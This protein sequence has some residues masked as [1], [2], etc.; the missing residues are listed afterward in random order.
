MGVK[1]LG[2]VVMALA[3]LALSATQVIAIELGEL[4]AVPGTYPPYVFRLSIIFSLHGPSDIPSV[5]VRQPRDVLSLVKNNLLEL[6]LPS[7]TDVELEVNQGGQTLNRL[8]LKGELQAA[9]A[10]LEVATMAVRHQ[11]ATVK[12]RQGPAA[13]ARPLTLAAAAPPDQ[14]L[15]E[16]ELQE[17]RQAIQ[18]LMGRVT[19]W[20]GLST[21]AWPDEEPAV[22]PVFTLTLWGGVTIGL[23]SFCIGYLMRRQAIDHQQRQVLEASI[24]QLRGQLM[25][26]EI[27]RQP[28]QRAQFLGH[29]PEALGPVTVKRRVRVSQKTRRR[30]RVRASRDSYEAIQVGMAGHTQIIA[31]LSHTKRLAPAEVVEALG[32]LRRQ[33]IS[34]QQRLPHVSSPESSHAESPQATR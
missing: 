2:F 12:D 15:L 16:H 10:R 22:A 23:A 31:R 28:S 9:R 32:H 26:G 18:T 6:R 17:I 25:S 13:E 33:L 19:P 30:I 24:R 29:Q 7:L 5:T 27:T 21:P 8:L 34:L 4:Q 1:H 11:P 3:S 20:E 14:A